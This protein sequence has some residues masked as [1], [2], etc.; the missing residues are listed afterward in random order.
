MLI[1]V[2]AILR[3]LSRYT[4]HLLIIYI[5]ELG[6]SVL[7]KHKRSLHESRP[8]WL[9]CQSKIEKGSIIEIILRVPTDSTI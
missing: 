7:T 3:V 4:N 6:M 1:A 5:S 9:S 8:S 2:F